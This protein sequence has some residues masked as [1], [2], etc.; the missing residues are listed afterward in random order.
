MHLCDLTSFTVGLFYSYW[1]LLSV[2]ENNSE[3]VNKSYPLKSLNSV[4]LHRAVEQSLLI[5]TIL[6]SDVLQLTD[7]SKFINNKLK[8]NKLTKET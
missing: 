6:I 7:K 1:N 3:S 8:H 2:T 5:T 4:C